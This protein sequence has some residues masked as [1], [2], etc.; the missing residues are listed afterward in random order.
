MKEESIT[1]EELS[2]VANAKNK[3]ALA[4]AEAKHATAMYHLADCEAKNLLLQIYNKY[5]LKVGQDQIRD[6]GEIVRAPVVKTVPT[7]V[8]EDSKR[9]TEV[10]ESD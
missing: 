2:A 1:P 8:Q 9:A 6:T 10:V 3:S 5:G 4:N 7:E